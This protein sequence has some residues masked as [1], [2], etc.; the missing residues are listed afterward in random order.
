MEV[1][2]ADYGIGLV[3][4][5][6]KLAEASH[7]AAKSHTDHVRNDVKQYIRVL[8]L[9]TT[10]KADYLREVLSS[11]LFTK[12][13]GLVCDTEWA[14]GKM[15]AYI[16]ELNESSVESWESDKTKNLHN[17]RFRLQR[18]ADLVGIA[19]SMVT[20]LKKQTLKDQNTPVVQLFAFRDQ[21]RAQNVKMFEPVISKLIARAELVCDDLDLWL[22]PTQSS[23][24]TRTTGYTHI[25]RALVSA[26]SLHEN[27]FVFEDMVSQ[28]IFYLI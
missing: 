4:E 10:E 12:I 21:M 11:Q 17:C 16:K 19:I 18:V 9:L 27:S 3:W 24:I 20:I 2:I 25:S 13:L 23:Q 5:V 22:P 7:P 14:L 26:A 8:G 15:K 28:A 6:N 1:A